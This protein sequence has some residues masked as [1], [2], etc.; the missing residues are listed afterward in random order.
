MQ[1]LITKSYE[2]SRNAFVAESVAMG[3]N[4]RP[5]Q[6]TS[7]RYYYLFHISIA[8]SNLEKAMTIVKDALD[9]VP[10]YTSIARK[11]KIMSDKIAIIMAELNKSVEF[12]AI[13]SVVFLDE[14]CSPEWDILL[15]KAEDKRAASE[16]AYLAALVV[17]IGGN[18]YCRDGEAE[19]AFK[20][21]SALPH[22]LQRLQYADYHL[23][24]AELRC[25]TPSDLTVVR[26]LI[27]AC[28]NEALIS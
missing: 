24:M 25:Q 22:L 26:S 5:S 7:N 10:M 6:E 17:D 28:A 19:A 2:A 1:Q 21:Y 12:N 14:E 15:S 11:V 27:Y 8:A 16:A 23:R 13:E 4:P 3:R 9:Y 18:A 20:V